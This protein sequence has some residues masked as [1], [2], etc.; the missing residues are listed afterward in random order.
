MAECCPTVA[1]NLELCIRDGRFQRNTRT[2]GWVNVA[3]QKEIKEQVRTLETE[4]Q[5]PPTKE[6]DKG[7]EKVNKNTAFLKVE[8]ATL[9]WAVN[10][11]RQENEDLNLKIK[12]LEKRY[13]YLTTLL[14]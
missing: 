1:T 13:D 11:L 12:F 7:E 4:Q 8:N 9:R 14:P 2:I 5:A 6:S 3:T 10:V